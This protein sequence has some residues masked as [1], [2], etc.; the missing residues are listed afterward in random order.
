MKI[1]II[2]NAF[3][4]LNNYIDFTNKVCVLSDKNVAKIYLSYF[5][6]NYV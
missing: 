4:N 2:D 3:K 1:E 6:G 5:R